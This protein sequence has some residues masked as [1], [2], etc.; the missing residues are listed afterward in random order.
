MTLGHPRS[1]RIHDGHISANRN[2]R[3][4]NKNVYAKSKN[5]F[6]I[7]LRVTVRKSK[8]CNK[9]PGKHYI[10]LARHPLYGT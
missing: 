5:V 4:H 9:T 7:S 2:I 6:D 3:V 1:Q 10:I 8:V